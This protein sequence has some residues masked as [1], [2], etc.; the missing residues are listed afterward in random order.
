MND[1]S[2]ASAPEA[3][4][5]TVLLVHGAFAESASWNGVVANLQ[6]RGYPVI[7]VANP[8]RGVEPD[9]AYLRSVIDSQPGPLVIAGHSYGGVVMSEAA[10]GAPNVHGPRLHRELQPG[11]RRERRR[12]GRQVPR[13]PARRGAR[14][15]S[16]PAARRRDGHRPLHPAGTVPRGVRRRCRPGRSEADGRDPTADRRHRVADL[17]TKAAWKSIPSWTMVTRQDL[18]IPADS[19]R[20]MAERAGSTTVEIDA[21]HAV[22][23]SQPDAVADL[24]DDAARA[25]TR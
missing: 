13:W 11:G 14:P 16:L 4:L 7:A 5:P 17:A 23:V 8:L 9:A 6:R 1:T 15:R 10:E 12:A 25:T 18:A 3:P 19:M 22:T 24:I 20:F 21:S 2:Q